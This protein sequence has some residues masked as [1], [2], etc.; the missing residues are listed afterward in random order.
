[1]KAEILSTGDEIR[2][3]AVV[4]SNS[5]FI[6]QKLE[7]TG[8]EV[9]RHSCIGDDIGIFTTTL[10][11]ISSRVDLAVVT[12]GL[13]PTQ[14]DI[15]ALAASKAAGVELI[16]DETALASVENFFKAHKRLFSPSNQ[17]QA[18]LPEGS[19]CLP[20]PVGTAPGFLITIGDCKFF[21][22]PGV[23]SEMQHM[24]L[25]KVLPRLALLQGDA[26]EFSKVRNIVTFG[27]TESATGEVLAN[28][29]EKFPEVKLGLRA[30]FPEI[31]VKLYARDKDEN[32]LDDLLQQ[33]T[34]WVEQMIGKRVVSV[35]GH[36]MEAAVGELLR[37]QKSTLAIAESCTGGLVSHS[38]TD[39][40][41][42]SDYFLLSAVT[43]SNQAKI[44]VL[45]VPPS[46]L[47][48]YG[49]VHEETAQ[50]MAKGVRQISGATYG[51]SITGIAGPEGGTAEKPVGTVCIGLATPD[52]I[53]GR[54]YNF[55]FTERF[56]NKKIYATTA[57]NLLRR[58]L[59]SK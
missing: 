31:H 12:G 40:S 50:E 4:D 39:I 37:R 54:R 17:K 44:K 2:S 53:E 19:E 10:K 11:E 38:L 42:S 49:A 27:L 22:L 30:I 58:R 29:S 24:I 28:F 16:L 23:P 35:E 5:A 41:G 45:G 59:L 34:E 55:P 15:S 46:V 9:V 25:D 48:H 20:N 21:F 7:E 51:L 14:D 6:A 36:S 3:G 52:G 8:L 33:A 1:M 47:E 32:H 43:Y 57:L 26:R 18:M 13:G 56:M